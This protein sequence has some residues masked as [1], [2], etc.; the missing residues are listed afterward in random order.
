MTLSLGSAIID[1]ATSAD[2]IGNNMNRVGICPECG[3]HLFIDP[4]YCP[5]C[6]WGR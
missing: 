2:T 6:K 5:V 4:K 3:A 1:I